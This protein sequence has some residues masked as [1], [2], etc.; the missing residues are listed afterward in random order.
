MHYAAVQKFCL[1]G[2]PWGVRNWKGRPESFLTPESNIV[3]ME[4]IIT[5]LIIIGDTVY[6]DQAPLN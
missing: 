6:S 5:K 1:S 2:T 3:F 4:I